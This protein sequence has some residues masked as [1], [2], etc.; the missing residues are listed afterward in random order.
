M[1]EDLYGNW[2]Q[3]APWSE[4]GSVSMAEVVQS[5]DD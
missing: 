1:A 2:H 3:L 5:K 4:R